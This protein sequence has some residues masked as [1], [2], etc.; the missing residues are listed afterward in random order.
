[1][2]EDLSEQVEWAG[3]KIDKEEWKRLILAAHYGQKVVPNPFG[4]GF[5]IM[6]NKRSR[7]L[8][9]TGDEGI[10]DLITQMEAFGAEKGV[11]WSGELPESEAA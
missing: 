3:A 11:V 9:K 1:M 6:N 10:S 5:V 8:A 7:D 4:P 2:C